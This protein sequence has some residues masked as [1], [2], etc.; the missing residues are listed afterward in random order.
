VFCAYRPVRWLGEAEV[1]RYRAAVEQLGV[2]VRDGNPVAALR[3]EPF[4]AIWFEY[5]RPATPY[6]EKVRFWQPAATVLI[7][8]VDINFNRFYRIHAD[9]P[10]PIFGIGVHTTD[11]LY[12]AKSQSIGSLPTGTLSPG[13]Y[14]VSYKIHRFPFLPGVHSLRRGVALGGTFQPV[15]YSENVFSFQGLGK[16]INRTLQSGSREG[17]VGLDGEWELTSQELNKASSPV[18]IAK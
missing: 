1:N 10:A 15:P 4:D 7:D 14:V 12:L 9:L 3:S 18:A 11:F 2:T 8:S 13:H 16:Q 5:Y 6:S 17:F